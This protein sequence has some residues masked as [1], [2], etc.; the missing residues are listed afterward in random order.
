MVVEI[1]QTSEVRKTE[2]NGDESMFPLEVS[3]FT[4]AQH[5]GFAAYLHF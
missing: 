1:T 5:T 4:I 2:W 3:L